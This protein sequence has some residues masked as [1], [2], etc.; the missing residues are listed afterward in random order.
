MYKYIAIVLT[1]FCTVGCKSKKEKQDPE[2]F[3]PVISYI[4]GQVSQMDSSLA[5]IIQIQKEMNG[6]ADTTYLSRQEFRLAAKDF[7][8]LPEISQANLRD[9]YE[10]ENMYDDLMNAFV[11]T[12]TA[13]DKR[14]EIQ[15]ED[16]IVQPNENGSSDIKAINFDRWRQS[17]DST[18]HQNL[19]WESGK[20][21]VVVTKTSRNNGPEKVHTL[22]VKWNTALEGDRQ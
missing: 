14:L 22:E 8:S 5:T 13:K 18:V 12:F 4:Q 7:L 6:R 2:Q 9:D 16:V 1:L 21:F 10:A 20:R 19:L 11:F 15:R 17:R 3:I